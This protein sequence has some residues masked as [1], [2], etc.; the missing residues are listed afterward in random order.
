MT[1]PALRHHIILEYV[2]RV[3]VVVTICIKVSNKSDK[4]A[5][6]QRMMQQYKSDYNVQYPV[7]RQSQTVIVRFARFVEYCLVDI[8]LLT[9]ASAMSRNAFCLRNICR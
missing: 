4:L 8:A 7:I 9:A 1:E 3:R 6:K 2:N 5:K